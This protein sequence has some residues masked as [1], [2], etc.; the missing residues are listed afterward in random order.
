MN[1]AEDIM[2]ELEERL[3]RSKEHSIWRAEVKKTERKQGTESWWPLGHH[4]GIYLELKTE[5]K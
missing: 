3:D 4:H 2:S 1:T 5:K